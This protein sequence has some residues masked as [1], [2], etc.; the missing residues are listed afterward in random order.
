MA[1]LSHALCLNAFFFTKNMKHKATG[2]SRIHTSK[3]LGIGGGFLDF[4]TSRN[5]KFIIWIFLCMFL[6]T[7]FP[8]KSSKFLDLER[9]PLG[10]REM[11]NDAKQ[12]E[13]LEWLAHVWTERT[14]FS[15]KLHLATPR[16]VPF[17]LYPQLS[18]HSKAVWLHGPGTQHLLSVIVFIRTG[19]F[20]LWSLY[21]FLKFS[22][23]NAMSQMLGTKEGCGS[24]PW[25]QLAP[26]APNEETCLLTAVWQTCAASFCGHPACQHHW[27]SW[28]KS[29]QI[30]TMQAV[31]PHHYKGCEKGI[32][33]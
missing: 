5:I 11:V 22:S 33:L 28:N 27:P 16:H 31:Y 7:L 9:G 15:K 23:G 19:C 24:E 4:S 13:G 17:P 32:L 25:H 3:M 14:A 30:S 6:Y 29:I 2:K 12:K 21:S 26:C 1:P 8:D 20:S 18:F 10:Q